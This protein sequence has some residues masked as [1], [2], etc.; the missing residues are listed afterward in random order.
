MI[1]IILSIFPI[2]GHLNEYLQIPWH[3]SQIR[4][5]YFFHPNKSSKEVERI[6]IV[7]K[8]M[9]NKK[10]PQVNLSHLKKEAKVKEK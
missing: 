9:Q 5:N 2:S 10:E 6:M 3:T 1:S 7:P 8:N 4:Q